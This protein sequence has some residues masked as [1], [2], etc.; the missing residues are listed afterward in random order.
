MTLGEKIKFAR[1]LKGMTQKEL[2]LMVGFSES[3]ADNRIRQYEMGKMKPKE[4]KLELIAN[5]LGV[6]IDAL[7]DIDIE[8]QSGNKLPHLLFELERNLGLTVDKINGKYVMYFDAETQ[9]GDHY[10]ESLSDWYHA[11]ERFFP[12]EESQDD[13]KA[14]ND[15]QLW[16]YEYPFNMIAEEEKI[17]NE[18]KAKYEK[19]IDA[20]KKGFK[21][22]TVSDYIKIFENMFAAGITA[23]IA[24]ENLYGAFF[25]ILCVRIRLDHN[26]L[27]SLNE[28]QLSAYTKFIAMIDYLWDLKQDMENM[29]N[30]M[31]GQTCDEYNIIS[32]TLATATLGT[33]KTLQEHFIF[34]TFEDEDYQLEYQADLKQFNIPIEDAINMRFCEETD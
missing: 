7:T 31:D 22:K 8:G 18:I 11:R 27:L 12:T 5:A 1:Q 3:T 29:T 10:N 24:K 25:D 20:A 6:D 32:N 34:G 23:N 4:D 28:K 16:T 21:I 33:V 14:Y 2:G 9:L 17:S 13:E 15:Y 30:T 26:M 19:Q